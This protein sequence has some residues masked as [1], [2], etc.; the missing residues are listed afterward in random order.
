M[1]NDVNC[2]K[3][4]SYISYINVRKTIYSLLDKC[5]YDFYIPQEDV[6]LSRFCKT[7]VI[8]ELGE[9]NIFN[10]NFHQLCVNTM[11]F[12]NTNISLSLLEDW[13]NAC[14]NEQWIYGQMDENFS[15]SCPEQSILNNIIANRIRNNYIPFY[16][17]LIRFKFRNINHDYY[18]TNFEY[19]NYLEN[20][21]VKDLSDDTPFKEIIDT[22]NIEITNYNFNTLDFTYKNKKLR[23]CKK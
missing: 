20:I 23:I 13:E 3:Y 9:D 6:K 22:D 14:K 5:K 17:P 2:F 8:R 16:Y 1:Y 10:Y 11:I 15:H 12:K 7:N 21:V 19:L 4:A 18:N